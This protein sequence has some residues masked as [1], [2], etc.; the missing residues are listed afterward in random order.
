MVII[1]KG[2]MEREWSCKQQQVPTAIDP[3]SLHTCRHRGAMQNEFYLPED[4][5]ADELEPADSAHQAGPDSLSFGRWT[6]EQRQVGR[7]RLGQLPGRTPGTAGE[8]PPRCTAAPLRHVHCLVAVSRLSKA[9]VSPSLVSLSPAWLNHAQSITL[10]AS[11]PGCLPFAPSSLLF[12]SAFARFW[13]C[14]LCVHPEYGSL[15]AGEHVLV[16]HEHL[17]F[18]EKR[19]LM[20]QDLPVTSRQERGLSGPYTGPAAAAAA[21]NSGGVPSG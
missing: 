12:S 13:L 5:L 14:A 11:E 20:L 7:P 8:E 17:L 16:L 9:D 2:P 1:C 19:T 18:L 21:A 3:V 10:A 6:Q 4:D 15:I